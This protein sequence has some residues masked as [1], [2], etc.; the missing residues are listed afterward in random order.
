MTDDDLL[1]IVIGVTSAFF[2]WM[3]AQITSGVRSYLQKRKI[4]RLLYEE[5]TDLDKAIDRIIVFYAR[6][7]QMYGARI[8]GN[9]TV[10]GLSNPIF[11]NYYKDG[12]ISLNQKQR[13]SYQLIH[14]L[15]EMIN[16]GIINLCDTTS[17]IHSSYSPDEKR[18]E[19]QKSC[20]N[21]G[22]KAKSEFLNCAALQ[23]QIR[24]HILHK[25]NPDLKPYT[26]DHQTFLQ[27]LKSAQEK[28]DEYM[29]S[30]KELDA[31]SFNELYHPKAFEHVTTP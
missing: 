23:W 15:V 9:S 20:D 7:I 19:I 30:G 13:I 11:T 5:L 28:A 2:G 25:K 27:Y 21:W 8:I 17:K 3:L 14:S 22:E 31:E 10:A 16:S 26:K 1:K 18:K 24:F 4:L 12:L 29:A 6:N